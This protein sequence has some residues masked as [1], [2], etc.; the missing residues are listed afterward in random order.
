MIYLKMTRFILRC[1]WVSELW[2]GILSLR[3]DAE[4]VKAD[5]YIQTKDYLDKLSCRAL[6]SGRLDCSATG[7][8]FCLNNVVDSSDIITISLKIPKGSPGICVGILTQFGYLDNLPCASPVI[9]SSV[10]FTDLDKTTELLRAKKTDIYRLKKLNL[11]ASTGDY[12]RHS[13]ITAT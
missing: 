3:D 4:G 11:L 10:P 6:Y 2:K 5:L 1:G 7:A 8:V 13:D 9:L 12:I